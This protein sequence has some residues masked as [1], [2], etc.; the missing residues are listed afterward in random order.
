MRDGDVV[1]ACQQACA[2]GSITFGDLNDPE[3]RVAK[4]AARDRHYKLLAEIGTQPR[5]VF[6]AKVRNPNPAMPGQVHAE[7]H[8]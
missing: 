6:L 7:A 4:L 8:Q 1:V 5:T 2:A 3:S